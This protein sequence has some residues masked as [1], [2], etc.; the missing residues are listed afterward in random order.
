MIIFESFQSFS[1]TF[2]AVCGFKTLPVYWKSSVI[3]PQSQVEL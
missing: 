3:V 1:V 2:K